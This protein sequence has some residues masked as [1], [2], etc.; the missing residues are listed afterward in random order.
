MSFFLRNFG[1]V[2][3][4]RFCVAFVALCLCCVCCVAFIVLCLYCV[5]C[6]VL[7]VGGGVVREGKTYQINCR[8]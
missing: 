6:D 7:G 1:A 5:I 8:M 4:L 3:A 2:F